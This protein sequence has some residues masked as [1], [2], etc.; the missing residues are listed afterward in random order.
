MILFMSSAIELPLLR[1]HHSH[2]S[3]YAALEGC[4]SIFGMAKDEALRRLRCLPQDRLSIALGWSSTQVSFTLEELASLPPVVIVNRSLHGMLL[5]PGA[6]DLLRDSDPELVERHEDLQWCERNLPAVLSLYGRFVSLTAEKLRVYMERLAA[7]GVGI[8]EDMLILDEKALDVIQASPWGRA[9]RCWADPGVFESFSPRGRQAVAGFK[10]FLDGALAI[11]TAALS[12]PYLQGGAGLL[13]H[14]D[15]ELHE[16]LAGLCR[17]GKPVAVHAIGARAIGQALA[18]LSR[19][20]REGLRFPAVRLE[21]VQFIDE[22]QA[23]QAQDLGIILS[24]QP[25]FSADSRDYADRLP[26]ELRPANNPFRMLIDRA[27]FRPGKDLIFGSDGMPHGAQAAW[28]WGLFPDHEGQRLTSEELMQG[29]G[30][31]VLEGK[32]GR[33]L[34]DESRRLVEFWE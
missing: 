9:L 8:A 21:H 29:Y 14:T 6:K 19:L 24:M 23:R 30:P 32:A 2:V 12:K 7:L 28:Q 20:D 16:R 25:N 17:F 1:D 27:G 13:L 22:P 31:K 34:V 11:R 4:P 33:L 5:S 10:I 3:L 18:I 26:P 15:D